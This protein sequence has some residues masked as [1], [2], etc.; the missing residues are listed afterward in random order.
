MGGSG[1]EEEVIRA[2]HVGR[3]V[4]AREPR[5]QPAVAGEKNPPQRI[6]QCPLHLVP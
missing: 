6:G 2:D 5:V 4:L 1:L 3:Y